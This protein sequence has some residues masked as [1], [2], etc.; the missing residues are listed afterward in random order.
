MDAFDVGLCAIN[1]SLGSYVTHA[2]IATEA[3][4]IQELKAGDT[5]GFDINFRELLSCAFEIHSW[6]STWQSQHTS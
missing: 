6:G 4:R 1:I 3:A 5:N 2:F